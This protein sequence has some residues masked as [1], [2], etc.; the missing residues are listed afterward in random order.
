MGNIQTKNGY[1]MF[2][3]ISAFQKEIRRCDEMKAM[4]WAVELYE[5]GFIPYAWKR[6]TVIC[7]EDIGLADPMA[8]VIINALHEQYQ[9]L[10]A[11]KDDRK[12][13]NRLPFVQAVLY[14]VHAPKSRIT[15]WALNYHFDSHYFADDDPVRLEIPDYAL[16]IH[17]WKG[18]RILKKTIRDFFTEGSLVNQHKVMENEEFYK[19]K[20]EERWTSEEW[21]SRVARI[22]EAEEAK[23][24]ARQYGRTLRHEPDA[25]LSL[26]TFDNE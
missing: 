3:V 13:Q 9:R 8:P 24:A 14:L 17:T 18:K 19:R 10:S 4:Y 23:T 12:Q 20:C 6:M 26:F 21:L 5:S 15:D 11:A 1:D 22:K 2:E 16:D 25:D 7:T